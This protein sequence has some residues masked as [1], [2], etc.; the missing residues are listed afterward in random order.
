MQ[1]NKYDDDLMDQLKEHYT[2]GL[3][4]GD[5]MWDAHNA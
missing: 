2:R 5:A 4:L 3:E 1:S